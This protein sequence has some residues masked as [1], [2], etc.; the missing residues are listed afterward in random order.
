MWLTIPL[1]VRAVIPETDLKSIDPT[2]DDFLASGRLGLD[3]S[4]RGPL[5]SPDISG[6]IDAVDLRL[7]NA[8]DMVADAGAA[9][10]VH[11]RLDKPESL[12]A[13]VDISPT[14]T[15]QTGPGVDSYGKCQSTA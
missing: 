3:I 9:I 4:A 5:L 8:P 7:P 14:G 6:R 15:D 11:G 1:I 13:S 10:T 2:A 12:Q